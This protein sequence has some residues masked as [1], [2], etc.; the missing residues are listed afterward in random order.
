MTNPYYNVTGAPVASSR[1]SSAVI[2]NEFALIQK[3]FDSIAA[4][5]GITNNSSIPLGAT[6]ITLTN[7]S[8]RYQRI[9]TAYGAG[10]LILPDAT[11]MLAG[12]NI[13][14]IDNLGN[15]PLNSF[16]DLLIKDAAG[17][18]L[19]FLAPGKTLPLSPLHPKRTPGLR[20]M[21]L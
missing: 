8:A 11:T 4:A 13:F 19:G 14:F 15:D 1:G 3:G 10:V 9:S 16:G 5:Q 18:M 2:D 20:R 6:T 7:A 12:P 21:T 17:N